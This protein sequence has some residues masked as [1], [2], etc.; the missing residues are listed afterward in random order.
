MTGMVLP[1][2]DNIEVVS[3]TLRESVLSIK[4]KLGSDDWVLS[5]TMHVKGGL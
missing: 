5:P 4:L 2:L 3:F 1:R